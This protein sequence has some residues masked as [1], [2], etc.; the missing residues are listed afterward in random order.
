VEAQRDSTPRP[1]DSRARPAAS[2]EAWAERYLQATSIADK[3]E[4][5][6]P[7]D[8]WD[9]PQEALV[10]QRPGR[11][12]ALQTLE[13]TRRSLRRKELESLRKRAELFHTFLHHELQAAELM[14]WAL[15]AFPETPIAFR[16]G[17]LG[18]CLDEIRHLQLYDRWLTS[19]GF[20]YG[21]FAVRDWFWERVGSCRTPLQFVA[22]MG[23]GL[24]GGNLDHTLRYEE[25]FREMGDQEAA[26]IQEQICREEIPHVRFAIHW[27]R[28]WTGGLEFERWREEIVAPLSPSLLQG[29]TLNRVARE[30]G[31]FD[32]AFLEELITWR[33]GSPGS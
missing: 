29:K 15:L 12:P 11:D 16:K 4:P 20:H 24:E 10:I 14:C 19:R 21:E 22:L 32:L 30:A 25:W 26:Q 7:P 5:A 17:L 27:F 23:M 3:L 6:P 28:T 13:K 8:G 2:V 31:G 18:I 1:P 9:H 33:N